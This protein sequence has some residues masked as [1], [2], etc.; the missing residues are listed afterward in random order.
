MAILYCDAKRFKQ[1]ILAGAD[2]VVNN[3]SHLNKINVFPVPDGDTGS[4][5]SMTLIAAV[6]EIEALQEVSLET[7]AKAAA[8]GSLMGARGNSGIIMAQILAG[9]AEGIEGR[10]RLFAADIVFAFSCAAKKAYKAILHPAEGT[11]LT[12]VRETSEAAEKVVKNEQDFAILLDEMVKAAWSSVERTPLLLP[13]LKEAGVVDAGGLGF[14]YFLEGMVRL[15]R[16]DMKTGAVIDDE[17]ILNGTVAEPVEH[18]WNY[19]YCTEFIL[20]GSRISG[21]AMKENLVRMGDSIVLVGDTRLARVHIHTGQPEEV[22][23]YASSLG[24]VSSIKVDDMLVQHTSRFA[25][26]KSKKTTSVVAVVLGDGLKEI[27]Y[28]AGSELVV[29]GG[30]TQNPSTSDIVSAIE[31]VTS[32]NVIILPNH[33]NV[34]PAAIQAAGMTPKEVTVLKTSSAPEGLS[35]LLAYMDDASFEKNVS[36]MEGAWDGV[37]SGEVA[38]ASRSVT[39]GEIEVKTGDSIGIYRGEIQCS[40]ASAGETVMNL[41]SSMLDADDEIITL[42]YGDSIGKQDAETLQSA[43]Q[44]RFKDKTVELYYGGQPYAQYIIS[45]E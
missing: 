36:N 19:R 26:Q 4:N 12:V 7:T 33:K 18:Q 23:R 15:I 17:D 25:N 2:R 41:A 42:F 39:A 9:V 22:L 6:R 27:F 20:K 38:Q 32:S 34:Y 14:Y 8:W 13:R 21:D 5:M 16:G 29:D 35:A 45:I 30:P 11:I 43:V 1:V 28:N 31:T 37:K 40:S 3:R 10:E 44:Q 24:Q